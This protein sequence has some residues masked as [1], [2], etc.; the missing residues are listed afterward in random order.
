M[1]LWRILETAAPTHSPP[2]LALV[3]FLMVHSIVHSV[4][5]KYQADKQ[6]QVGLEQVNYA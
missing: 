6:V 5:A 4:A 2:L 3:Q 1:T